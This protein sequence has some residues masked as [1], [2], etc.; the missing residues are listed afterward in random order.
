MN[1]TQTQIDHIRKAHELALDA[2]RELVHAYQEPG[3]VPNP[4]IQKSSREVSAACAVLGSIL[5][6]WDEEAKT[7]RWRKRLLEQNHGTRE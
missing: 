2:C 4:V 7:E 1:L 6:Q 3:Q 5:K